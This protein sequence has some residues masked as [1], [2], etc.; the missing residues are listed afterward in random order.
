MVQLNTSVINWVEGTGPSLGT[1]QQNSECD[2]LG[3]QITLL[4]QPAIVLLHDIDHS[5]D[6][7]WSIKR[8]AQ[9]YQ[10]VW[11]NCQAPGF[12][13]VGPAASFCYERVSYSQVS[14]SLQGLRHLWHGCRFANHCKLCI[15]MQSDDLISLPDYIYIQDPRNSVHL[16]KGT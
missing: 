11:K 13:E 16:L 6:R 15:H 1:V 8:S 14:D 10:H 4:A 3:S 5:G 7:Q 2:E 9:I 12:I